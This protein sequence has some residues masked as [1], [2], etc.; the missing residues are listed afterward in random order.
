MPDPIPK[1]L[2]TDDREEWTVDDHIAYARTGTAPINPEW[3]SRRNEALEDAG[4]E[5]EDDGPKSMEDAS[6]REHE[7]RKYGER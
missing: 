6:V 3:Q 5:L 2:P 4:L 1:H 7:V